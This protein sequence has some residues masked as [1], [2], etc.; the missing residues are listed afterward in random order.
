MS[1]DELL[2]LKEALEM[3][4]LPDAHQNEDD[5]LAQG[6][7]QDSGIR[8]ITDLPESLL[9]LLERV[10]ERERMSAYTVCLAT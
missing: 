10:R 5:G 9:T 7:P 2:G 1:L 3:P 8:A 6:P 4:H